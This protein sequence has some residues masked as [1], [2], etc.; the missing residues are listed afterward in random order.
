[1]RARNAPAPETSKA[2]TL[3]AL[4]VP[5]DG[6]GHTGFMNMSAVLDALPAELRSRIAGCQLK[7]DPAHTLQ[8]EVRQG[9]RSADVA[10]LATTPGPIHPLVRT[11]PE[12]GRQALYL[13]R[14]CNGP[15]RSGY[16]MGLTQ[17][18]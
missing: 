14:Q 6:S 13:G 17:M 12:T 2:S 18:A 8:G 15:W 1:M 9:F 11:H 16:V 3:Y 10:D 4:E 5:P 7:H